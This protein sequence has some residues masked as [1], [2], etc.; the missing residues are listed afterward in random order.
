MTSPNKSKMANGDRVACRKML[1][2]S[3]LDEDICLHTISAQKCNTTQ[4]GKL[5]NKL[6]TARRLGFQAFSLQCSLVESVR[7]LMYINDATQDVW[8]PQ[9]RGAFTS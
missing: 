4:I 5:D 2:I 9:T 7:Q 6:T 8:Q 1:I 3:V